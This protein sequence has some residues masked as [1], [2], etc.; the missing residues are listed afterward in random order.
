[1]TTNAKYCPHCGFVCWHWRRMADHIVNCPDRPAKDR[2]RSRMLR[3]MERDII[4]AQMYR[5]LYELELCNG[6]E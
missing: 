6:G 5:E 4:H 3:D 2:A 1:M